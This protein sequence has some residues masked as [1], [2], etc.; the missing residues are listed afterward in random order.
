MGDRCLSQRLAVG[1][2]LNLRP[3]APGRD[4]GD[5]PDVVGMDCWRRSHA[6]TV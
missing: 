1:R 3:G 2:R 5:S 4:A 6:R